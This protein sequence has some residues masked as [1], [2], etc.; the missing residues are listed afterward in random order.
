[1]TGK[2]LVSKCHHHMF[3]YHYICL[4]NTCT[5]TQNLLDSTYAAHF[6]K[7]NWLLS[8][9]DELPIYHFAYLSGLNCLAIIVLYLINFHLCASAFA[10]KNYRL[11]R[12]APT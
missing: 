6:E 10:I 4:S 12:M 11:Q 9:D 8:S 3:C 2:L 7:R 1:M 5:M